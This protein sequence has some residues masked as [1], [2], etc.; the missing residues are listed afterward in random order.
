MNRV[1]AIN[2]IEQVMW[3]ILCIPLHAGIPL[4]SLLV[5]RIFVFYY[6][7]G[8]FLRK[9]SFAVGLVVGLL[10]T[11]SANV[12]AGGTLQ[13]ISATLNHEITTYLYG[14]QIALAK[15]PISYNNTTYYPIRDLAKALNLSVKWD[16]ESKSVLIDAPLHEKYKDL[17]LIDIHNH[18]APMYEKSLPIWESYHIG[19]TVL[20]GD[21]S[22]PSA[23]VT[24]AITWEAYQKYPDRIIPFFS[25]FD[26]HDAAGIETVIENLE[27]GYLGIGE[28]VAASTIS[29][30]TSKVKWKAEHPMDGNL[31]EVYRLAAEYKVPVLLHIDP[32]TGPANVQL[33]EALQKYRD[34]IIIFAHHNVFNP[35]EN[36][37]RMLSDHPNLY[38][39]FFAGFTGYNAAS[40]YKSE[41]YIKIMEKYPDRFFL[42][43]DSAVEMTYAEAIPAMYEV[44]DMLTPETRKKVASENFQNIID[45]QPPTQTQ[46]E[47]LTALAEI[48]GV[49]VDLQSL[50]K[51]QAN[52]K[53]FE[54]EKLE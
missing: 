30:F 23:M 29:P 43:T 5:V 34:T 52:V 31:P 39:D 22:E 10:F 41:D 51:H 27:K 53:L 18:D 14:E 13:K 12:W 17:Q 21:V 8:R 35:P 28:T 44:L 2:N 54:L 24:D 45:A 11:F 15:P 42:S 37:E 36:M 26:M 6:K 25:G 16:G 32:T 20:F 7:G 38:V 48:H 47:R 3:T 40:P 4:Q 33:E 1:Q 9:K 50:N 19:K 46:L 49:N